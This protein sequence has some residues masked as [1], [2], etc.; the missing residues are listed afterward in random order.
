MF[1][2]R[3]LNDYDAVENQFVK[4]SVV[5]KAHLTCMK[6]IEN[7]PW[8]INKKNKNGK[9]DK[10]YSGI[11]KKN[12]NYEKVFGYNLYLEENLGKNLSKNKIKQAIFCYQS[13][14][15]DQTY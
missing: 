12:A 10:K 5:L 9:F 3:N 14:L 13:C 15:F 4:Q 1:P 7:L 6:L 11:F 8:E 2:A